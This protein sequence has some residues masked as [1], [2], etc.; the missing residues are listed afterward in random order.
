VNRDWRIV[1]LNEA[2]GYIE[3]FDVFHFN[4]RFGVQASEGKLFQ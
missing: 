3:D 1:I 2:V 4:S